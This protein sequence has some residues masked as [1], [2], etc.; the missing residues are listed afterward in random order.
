MN[1]KGKLKGSEMENYRRKVKNQ[2]AGFT[3]LEVLLALAA[4]S[5]GLMAI[6][7]LHTAAL[8]TNYSSNLR[9][10]A[11]YLA[12]DMADRI[13]TN[14]VGLANPIGVTGGAYRNLSTNI[15]GTTPANP[16]CITTGC[17]PAQLANYDYFAWVTNIQANLPNGRGVVC[18]DSSPTT[19]T[20]DG[21]GTNILI[22]VQWIDK[23][24]QTQLYITAFNG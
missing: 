9:T 19:F 1:T 5:V 16:N 6:A 3:L 7:R 14:P 2:K 15:N 10:Q 21:T 13:R 17:T 11:T 4:L 8:Q 23:N 24:G 12:Y 18:V 20:C 22:K